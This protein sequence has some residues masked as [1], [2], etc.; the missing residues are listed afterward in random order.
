METDLSGQSS[1][2]PN[3]LSPAWAVLGGS[4]FLIAAGTPLGVM[5]VSERW[6]SLSAPLGPLEPKV[7]AKTLDDALSSETGTT[8]A[9]ALRLGRIEAGKGIGTIQL[10]TPVSELLALLPA[11]AVSAFGSDAEG[12]TQN[13]IFM[14]GGASVQIESRP[15]TDQVL[16]I[17]LSLATCP[18]LSAQAPDRD[19]LPMTV[20]GLSLGSHLSRIQTV[21]GPPLDEKIGTGTNASRSW[22][23]D[24]VIFGFCPQN[25]LVRS[26]QIVAPGEKPAPAVATE[27]EPEV[28]AVSTPKTASEQA[29]PVQRPEPSPDGMPVIGWPVELA[30]PQD[31]QAGMLM[32]L[33]DGTSA[34]AARPEHDL[35]VAQSLVL[36]FKPV[37]A[38]PNQTGDTPA[39]PTVLQGPGTALAAPDPSFDRRLMAISPIGDPAIRRLPPEPPTADAQTVVTLGST[40]PSAPRTIDREPDDAQGTPSADAMAGSAAPETPAMAQQKAASES[41]DAKA[42]RIDLA[43]GSSLDPVKR[44]DRSFA[45]GALARPEIA[46]PR[47]IKIPT[48]SLDIPDPA[49]VENG[50]GLSRASRRELQHRLR[51][52]GHNPRGVDGIF[53]PNTRLA[54]KSF[55][56]S[57]GLEG[58]GYFDAATRKRLMARSHRALAKWRKKKERIK[59]RVA[60]VSKRRKFKTAGAGAP[61]FNVKTPT[62]RRVPGCRRDGTGTIISNQSVGCDFEILE[63]SLGLDKI[64]GD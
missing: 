28:A 13:H 64:F 52:V 14:V 18:A 34:L 27:K 25:D 61:L 1:T 24:G 36:P 44:S 12:E 62:A 6:G 53:G 30:L 5:L 42:D 37:S 17:T 38:V 57:N 8:Q 3:R 11:D 39:P 4:L 21:L 49:S 20:Q 23:Y 35:D 50:L 19:G 47:A 56:R 22:R 60:V 48:A 9:G 40:A 58:T 41:P 54:V 59:R 45:A 16:S 26:I 29:M 32:T 63:E 43:A 10:K 7:I 51:L 33:S 55:Q 15:S 2:K 31:N 46:T